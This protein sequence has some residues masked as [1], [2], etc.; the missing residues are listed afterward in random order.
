MSTESTLSSRSCDHCSKKKI[1]CDKQLPQC[2]T[3]LR[4][5]RIC[6]YTRPALQRGIKKGY[7]RSLEERLESLERLSSL[8]SQSIPSSS[9]AIQIHI[10]SPCSSNQDYIL[11]ELFFHYMYPILPIFHKPSFM[12]NWQSRDESLL[13]IM[14]AFAK[15]YQMASSGQTS[16]KEADAFYILSKRRNILIESPS[17]SALQFCFLC[18]VYSAISGV[19]PI[20]N[21]LLYQ[22]LAIRMVFVLKLDEE[23]LE[24]SL[25]EQEIRKR[26]WWYAFITDRQNVA[27]NTAVPCQMQ[28]ETYR[29]KSIASESKFNHPNANELLLDPDTEKSLSAQLVVLYNIL[30]KIGIFNQRESL[31]GCS[32]DA[33]YSTLVS[34]LIDW[35]NST[36]S[37]LKL[38]GS[39][40]M[41][42]C[43]SNFEHA[44]WVYSLFLYHLGFIL[45]NYRRMLE[46]VQGNPTGFYESNALKACLSSANAIT[47]LCRMIG[48]CNPN[49]FYI[50]PF[51]NPCRLRAGLVYG[52]IL[53]WSLEPQLVR[54][55]KLSLNVLFHSF[56][57]EARHSH[58]SLFIYNQLMKL[59]GKLKI[60]M[61]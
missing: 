30:G 44:I 25:V 14:F 1:K 10:T 51:S 55:V 43:P 53:K 7:L 19:E 50:G 26:L 29:V 58:V 9:S 22:G 5:N 17:L 35:F 20:E 40:S 39:V 60:E 13:N 15:R 23:C 46:D 8:P 48:I 57:N 12:E 2:E 11:L 47:D 56:L 38:L 45:L 18:A 27:I 37:H 54:E 4:K 16:F 49:F 42:Y 34:S 32:L 6:S 33:D 3:C 52:F 59:L 61:D 31:L 24:L 41:P 28:K 21:F 36:P